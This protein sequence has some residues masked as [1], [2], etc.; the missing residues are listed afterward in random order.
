MAR[1]LYVGGVGAAL[2]LSVAACASAAP[3]AGDTPPVG[4]APPPDAL[5]SRGPV[6]AGAP[7]H[8][9]TTDPAAPGMVTLAT[10]TDAVL[11]D[12][13]RRTGLAK[14]ALVVEDAAAVTWPDG[15]LGCPQPGMLYT[16]ALVPG[17]RIR[18]RAGDDLLD[19]HASR[20]GSIAL[21][22]AERATD[23]VPGGAQ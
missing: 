1:E 13:A 9:P 18:V 20:R 2:V 7:E 17:Y 11:E 16:Q 3:P 6:E 4:I 23:P 14:S 5:S 22:P 15:S 19:Y 21:C 12:A 8:A 10:L